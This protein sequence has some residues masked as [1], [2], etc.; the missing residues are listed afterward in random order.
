MAGSDR[1]R[2][3]RTWPVTSRLLSDIYL[4]GLLWA[5]GAGLLVT[6]VT[7]IIVEYHMLAILSGLIGTTIAVVFF[8]CG[9]SVHLLNRSGSWLLSVGSFVAQ[10]GVLGGLAALA[11]SYH[12]SVLELPCTL[13]MV[14][15]SLSW[16]VGV[17]VAGSQHKR[18]YD[19][20]EDLGG[21][22]N[23]STDSGLR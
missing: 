23:H 7:A 2:P 19:D 9:R 18:I 20:P 17:V 22:E 13:A 8:A 1:G 12:T 15:A 16:I 10:V 21:D 6:A 4:K 14:G 11:S 3:T 5:T